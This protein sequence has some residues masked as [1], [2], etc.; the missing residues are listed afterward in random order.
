MGSHERA[1]IPTPLPDRVLGEDS[2][3]S[4]EVASQNNFPEVSDVLLRFRSHIKPSLKVSSIDIKVG[5]DFNR[6]ILWK[7]R[8]LL[9]RT[10]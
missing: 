10:L 8:M 9:A 7:H 3:D 4:D 5:I 2:S 1:H 6:G